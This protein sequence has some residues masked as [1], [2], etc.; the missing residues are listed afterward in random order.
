M[1]MMVAS[2]GCLVASGHRTSLNVDPMHAIYRDVYICRDSDLK[3]IL[4]DVLADG[5]IERIIPVVDQIPS[6]CF[7]AM[8]QKVGEEK[9]LDTLIDR[10]RERY[11][12]KYRQINR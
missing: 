10:Q 7:A 3:G 5:N 2:A 11:T 9:L 6:I 1:D 12:E 4:G 8:V